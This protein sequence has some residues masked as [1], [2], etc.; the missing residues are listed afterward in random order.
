MPRVQIGNS[1][2]APPFSG[3][4]S[5]RSVR[6]EPPCQR[7]SSPTVMWASASMCAPECALPIRQLA[8]VAEPGLVPRPPWLVSRLRRCPVGF[9]TSAPG[10]AD[11]RGRAACQGTAH[12]RA[13]RSG[14]PERAAPPGRPRLDRCGDRHYA[15]RVPSRL[16][17]FDDA[18]RRHRQVADTDAE[19]LQRVVD[20]GTRSPPGACI[21][22]PSPPPFVPYGVNGDGVSSWPIVT[23]GTSIADGIR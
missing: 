3:P 18:L 7:C 16:D 19:R 17:Q 10:T 6:A 21:R 15:P 4:K 2:S 22:P 14:P 1:S 11:A 12:G 8:D 5:P 20:G 9:G 13:R 23:S